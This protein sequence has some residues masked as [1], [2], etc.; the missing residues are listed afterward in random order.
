MINEPVGIV[1]CPICHSSCSNL[2]ISIWGYISG[3]DVAH[4]IY[5]RSH[6]CSSPSPRS[7]A[8]YT[9]FAENRRASHL[10]NDRQKV[11]N[12]DTRK[13]KTEFLNW[14]MVYRRNSTFTRRDSGE[15]VRDDGKDWL[16][17]KRLFKRRLWINRDKVVRVDISRV[18]RDWDRHYYETE[19]DNRKWPRRPCPG[20]VWRWPHPNKQKKLSLPNTENHFLLLLRRKA[21]I[22][23]PI[24]TFHVERYFIN[25]V[26]SKAAW[27]SVRSTFAIL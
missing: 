20:N 23:N 18:H 4:H 7:N 25:N 10:F 15:Y 6:A 5:F 27:P 3:H 12:R 19:P 9:F 22:I 11:R 2:L 14:S 21:T 24:N 8:P 17:I 1:S 13:Q 16:D 26:K